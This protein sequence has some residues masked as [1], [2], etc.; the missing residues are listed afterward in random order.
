M[1]SW[2][3]H[4][5]ETPLLWSAGTQACHVVITVSYF[6]PEWPGCVRVLVCRHKRSPCVCEWVLSSIPVCKDSV[7]VCALVS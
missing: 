3:R 4:L 7:Y 6:P 5:D 1:L 2:S